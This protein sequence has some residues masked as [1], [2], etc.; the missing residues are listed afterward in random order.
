MK[1][2]ITEVPDE[3]QDLRKMEWLFHV[4]LD[5]SQIKSGTDLHAACKAA[6]ACIR[7]HQ[8]PGPDDR[9][10][11]AVVRPRVPDA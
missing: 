8:N 11:V 5:P 2:K 6:L 7:H 10:I 9:I 1:R 4:D 3:G